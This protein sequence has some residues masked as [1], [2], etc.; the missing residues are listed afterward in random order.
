L[1]RSD[2]PDPMLKTPTLPLIPV[3]VL[4][5]VAALAAD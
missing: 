5:P 2:D 3:R 1:E 4:K